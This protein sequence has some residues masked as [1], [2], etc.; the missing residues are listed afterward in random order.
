MT[1]FFLVMD[2][3][4]LFKN[5]K[6]NNKYSRKSPHKAVL[7]LTII[8]MYEKN[9]LSENIIRYD[10]EL[11]E[12]FNIVWDK[13]IVDEIR[14]HPIAYLPYW[15]MQSESF[16]HIVP[17][18]GKEDIITLLKDTHVKPSES[19]L[20][21]CVDYAEL[22]EDLYFL[23]TIPSGRSS[24]KRALLE[25]YTTLYDNQIEMLSSSNNDYTDYSAIAQNEYK[26]ILKGQNS[27]HTNDAMPICSQSNNDFDKLDEDLKILLYYEYYKYLW[28]QKQNR[29]IFLEICPTIYDLYDHIVT[30][31]IGQQ[32]ISPSVSFIYENFLVELKIALI[33]E[34]KAVQIIDSI[35][36][37]LS[38]LKG[39]IYQK[40]DNG[41]MEDV[42]IVTTNHIPESP[43]LINE[44]YIDDK[45]ENLS[46]NNHEEDAELLD[47]T[48]E[49]ASVR[50]SLI[51]KYGECVFST[52]G[53][54]KI[55]HGKPYRFNYKEMC[56]TAKD[57]IN[58]DGV[59]MRGSKKFVAYKN[60]D[61]YDI[62]DRTDYINQIEDFIEGP[63]WEQN[64]ICIC[65][66]WYDHVGKI[67]SEESGEKKEDFPFSQ[68]KDVVLGSF[69]NEN[70]LPPKNDGQEQKKKIRWRITQRFEAK[71]LYLNGMSIP[72]LAVF[73]DRTE[74]EIYDLLK[75][76]KLL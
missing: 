19:K 65:G 25:T 39:D 2:Y 23:M 24:L 66:K 49:N 70:G 30:K 42:D 22:D 8:E 45:N 41:T 63:C 54:I 40:Y 32:E 64:R 4:E 61:A 21:E 15:F 71:S 47:I 9:L 68:I 56:F 43:E 69:N 16:W 73:Y 3:I 53:K 48:V 14:F 36:N 11:T 5:L 60:S 13:V 34:D 29:S 28:E 46:N 38:I 59:W 35:E 58:V 31:P 62:L 20:I 76:M 27:G 17:K 1:F 26:K 74:E 55:F 10:E 52:D 50:C 75:K 37:A 67:I 51:N 18:R 12:Q 7:L 72:Q 6:T 44:N 57:I 33:G